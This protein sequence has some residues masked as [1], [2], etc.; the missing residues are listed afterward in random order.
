MYDVTIAN[1]GLQNLD[2]SSAQT[3]L[4]CG[5][6]FIVHTCNDMNLGLHRLQKD[7]TLS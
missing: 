1:E 2:I 4:K 6:I 3:A 7:H 5:D